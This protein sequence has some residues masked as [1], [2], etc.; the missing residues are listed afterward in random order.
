MPL[1][2]GEAGY[3]FALFGQTLVAN[4]PG[5]T[6]LLLLDVSGKEPRQ[7][8]LTQSATFNGEAV[9]AAT[10]SHLFRIA[11]GFILKGA[12]RHGSLVEEIV[13]TAHQKQTIFWA[14]P[15]DDRLAGI[16]RNFAEYHLF[17]LH[18]QQRYQV[19]CTSS[20]SISARTQL[21]FSGRR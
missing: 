21:P 19:P 8:G 5:S 13:A 12:L 6:Q 14:S 17:L 20:P 3:R 4:P 7:Q 10:P 1:F 15:F 2:S 9:F 18:G 16:D 11:N